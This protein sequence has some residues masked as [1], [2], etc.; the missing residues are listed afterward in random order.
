MML[1][2]GNYPPMASLSAEP[3]Y[4]ELVRRVGVAGR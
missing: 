2:L 3:R 1:F 4:Q